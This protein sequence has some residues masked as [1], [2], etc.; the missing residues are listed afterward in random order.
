M[1]DK[2]KVKIKTAGSKQIT[3]NE[4]EGVAGIL[5]FAQGMRCFGKGREILGSESRRSEGRRSES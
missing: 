2:T 3:H 5:F 4:E 1:S